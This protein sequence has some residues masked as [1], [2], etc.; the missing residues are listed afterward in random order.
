MLETIKLAE[1]AGKNNEVPVGAVVVRNGEIIG[2]GQNRRQRDCDP[3]A[4]AEI[5]ALRMAA[6]KT[7][8]WH[9]DDC[10]I[11]VT[12]EPCPMCAG[13]IINSRIK[14]VVFGAY[15]SKTGSCSNESVVNLFN[16]GFNHKPEV[17]GGIKEKECS[18]LMT[19]FFK[20]KR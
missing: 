6:Q 7:G 2:K 5:L 19:E 3:T 20:N 10:D 13:A 17:Y 4:H 16:L 9:L 14:T 8:S 12:V 11:Y 18:R 15:E 1:E